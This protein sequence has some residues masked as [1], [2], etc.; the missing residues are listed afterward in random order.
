MIQILYKIKPA[1]RF[2]FFVLPVCLLL[3]GKKKEVTRFD[4]K[5]TAP[6]VSGDNETLI[7]PLLVNKFYQLNAGQLL[8]FSANENSK[9][10]RRQ[11]LSVIDTSV[12]YGII[13]KPYH[14]S[15]IKQWLDSAPPDSILTAKTEKLF[16]D[17]A[18]AVFKDIYQGYALKPGAGFDPISPK[19][20][21]KDDEYLITCLLQV[22]SAGQL[23]GMI[24]LLEPHETEYLQL[25]KELKLQKEKN[26]KLKIQQLIISMNYFRWIHHFRLDKYIVVNIP[27]ANLRY[28]EQD[29]LMLFMKTVV[30][31]PSTPTPRFSAYFTEVIL[32][33]YWYVPGS[34]VMNEL[35][36]KIKRNPSVLDDMNM[37]V[38]DG[39][40]KILDHHKINWS[41]YN[42]NNFPYT[43]RQS[44]GCDNSL[45]VI[46]FNII[47]PYGVYLHDTNN[48][49]AFLSGSRFYSH[50]CMRIEEPIKLANHLLHEKLDT[51]FLQS[52]FKEQKPIPVLLDK[53]VPVFVIYRMAETD[54]AGKVRYYRDIYKLLK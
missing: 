42:S 3:S 20:S 48:K 14:Y 5:N 8:W 7:Y 44:T 30:G 46:K 35:L 26:D 27:A 31:K 12:E 40:G 28:Y 29:S 1:I 54:P 11:L 24:S 19:F 45:G 17:A 6:F 15:E 13:N 32:Y 34:I 41:S 33:P 22:H 16:T 36:P 38:I 2:I 47:S 23:W 53:P 25:K 4:T 52:C 21:D 50:G 49:T 10:L 9:P 39:S 18:I 43:L 37:Q 51:T